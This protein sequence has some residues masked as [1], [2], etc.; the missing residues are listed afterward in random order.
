MDTQH[1][2]GDWLTETALVADKIGDRL[3]VIVRRSCR[4]GGVIRW[5]LTQDTEAR[6]KFMR[7]ERLARKKLVD[8]RRGNG[9]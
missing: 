6:G 2:P 4:E 3:I 8:R 7:D 9:R 5:E 1:K